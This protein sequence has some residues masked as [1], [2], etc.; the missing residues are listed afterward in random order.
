MTEVAATL[1]NSAV[2]LCLVAGSRNTGNRS[3]AAINTALLSGLLS[4]IFFGAVAHGQESANVELS[5]AVATSSRILGDQL[6]NIS[7]LTG[8]RRHRAVASALTTAATRRADLQRLMSENPGA[9]LAHALPASKLMAVPTELAAV[10][11]Q[12]WHGFA[13]LSVLPAEADNRVQ[14]ILP[15][16]R[17]FDV[18]LYGD[19]RYLRTKEDLPV[20][21]VLFGDRA[22]IEDSPISIFV[23]TEL[24]AIGRSTA[25]RFVR[26]GRDAQTNARITGDIVEALV[27]D[28]VLQFQSVENL[29]QFK[30]RLIGAERALGPRTDILAILRGMPGDSAAAPQ[31]LQPTARS[32]WTETPKTVFFIRLEFPDLPGEPVTQ[33]TLAAALNG[34]TSD[35]IR[36]FSY[37][38]TWIEGSVSDQVVMLP[39]SSAVYTND[40]TALYEDAQLAFDAL[41]TGVDLSSFDIVGMYFTHIGAAFAGLGQIG[42]RRQWIQNTTSPRVLTHELGHN[43]GLW[44]SSLWD[45][46]DDNSVTGPGTLV[47]YGDVFDVM[48]FGSVPPGHFNMYGKYLLNWLTDSQVIDADVQGDG[49]YRMYR[50]DDEAADASNPL[51]IAVDKCEDGEYW[52]GYRQNYP[53]NSN[54]ANGVYLTWQRPGQVNSLLLDTTTDT[55]G[56]AFDAGI[57]IGRPYLDELG[58]V[59]ITPVLSGGVS[60]NEWVDIR[61]QHIPTES[62]GIVAPSP[63]L[64][65]VLQQYGAA[66]L[67]DGSTAVSYQWDFRDRSAREHSATL[68]HRYVIGGAYDVFVGITNHQ[69]LFVRRL[70]TV[71]VEDPLLQ[72]WEIVPTG[73]IHAWNWSSVATNGAEIVLAAPRAIAF[74]AD[75]SSWTS[76]T[77]DSNSTNVLPSQVVHTGLRWLMVGRDFDANTNSWV[78]VIFSSNDGI[79]WV[80]RRRGGVPLEDVA[81]SP[82]ICV[83]IGDGG[84]RLTS[85]DGIAWTDSAFSDPDQFREIEYGDGKF[86]ALGRTTAFP[87]AG[88]SVQSANGLAWSGKTFAIACGLDA[89]TYAKDAFFA[90]GGISLYRSTDGAT[91]TQSLGPNAATGSTSNLL[92]RSF[93]YGANI[94]MALGS[95]LGGTQS[96]RAYSLDGIFWQLGPADE[97]IVQAVA[98]HDDRFLL[99]GADLLR[100]PALPSDADFDGML[101]DWEQQ[102]GLDPFDDGD[103][104]ED[105]D[106]DGLVNQSEF[107]VGTNPD[108]PDSDGDTIIDGADD[109]PLDSAASI[110]TDGDGMPDAYNSNA[111]PEQIEASS[112]IVD[113][114]DD[115][116]TV[117]DSSDNCPLH[118]NP[119]QQDADQDGVGDACE[120]DNDDE[121]CFPVRSSEG[122]ITLVC[123]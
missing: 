15:D 7:V 82:T 97:E 92:I 17:V 112:L 107:F 33:E 1:R 123:L 49:I 103:A 10:V 108:F 14:L 21:A 96:H 41:A 44:H 104:F 88:Y 26:N 110:D 23:P 79:S 68:N 116:D 80:E 24:E 76:G 115:N 83:A 120:S 86:V 31:P 114:D 60:P 87:C 67:A 52:M 118:A 56:D 30:Q 32:P 25:L 111:T 77:V 94:F 48:G 19:R 28:R 75:G 102:F 62:G 58:C 71:M 36:A 16:G 59:D 66:P 5:S 61:I 85:P 50:F 69:G 13:Q 95:E 90:A 22:I 72:P 42:G 47:Q 9:V 20:H 113:D 39:S 99:I 91:F 89:L 105:L 11:E 8:S 37:G 101:D 106:F 93:S 74:T 119:L 43:Y 98:F 18:Q 51:A 38:K 3:R 73:I 64:A 34:P 6:A 65:R 121:L 2:Q 53:Q 81:C 63:A 45:T 117:L 122:Q 84:T 27:G 70:Q 35:A 29:E 4:C 57:A 40:M 54:L 109:F 78:G 46:D 12:R 55:P 100:S